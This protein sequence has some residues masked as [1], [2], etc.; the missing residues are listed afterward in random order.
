ML[1]IEARRKRRAAATSS[2]AQGSL[3]VVVDP[4]TESIDVLPTVEGE[5]R[6]DVAMMVREALDNVGG[7]E[8]LTRQAKSNAKAFLT[9]VNKLMPS[10]V[11][12]SGDIVVRHNVTSD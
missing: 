3:P 9:L 12:Q 10:Q 1:T 2:C 5:A 7:V 4:S 6:K 11:S 8:Y